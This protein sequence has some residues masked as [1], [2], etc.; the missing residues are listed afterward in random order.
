MKTRNLRNA[1]TLLLAGGLFAAH[2]PQA[3]AAAYA[4]GGSGQYRNEV[5]WLTWGGGVNGTAG[6]PLA[7][8]ATTSATI[9]VT[10]NQDLV[11]ECSLS[12]ISG[13]IESYRPGDWSGDA[14]DDMYNIGGTGAANQLITGIMGRTGTHGFTVECQ[15]TLGGLPYRIPGLVMADAESMNTTTEYL[16]GTAA[17]TWNVVEVYT[18]NGNRYD[19]RK[20][21]VGGGLQAIRFGN[22]GGEQNGTT[23]PAGVTFLTFDEAAYGPGESI[24]MAFEIL[25]GG[26]TAI[27]IGLLAPSADFGDAPGSYGDAAHLLRGLVAEPDGLAPGAGAIDINTPGFQLGQLAPP[28]SG[29]LGSIGPDGEPGT[30]A[31]VDADGDDSGGSAGSA[32]EDAWTSDTLAITGTAQPI[33]R[34]IACVGTGTV[35]GWIDFDHN[36]AFDPDERAQAACSGGAAALSWIVPA[37]V[38]PGSSYVRLRYATDAAEVQSPSGEAADGEAEDHAVELEL[39]VDVSLDKVVTPTNASVGQVVD[40]TVTVGNAGPFAADGAVVTD[41]PVDGLDCAPASV[42]ACSAS[43]GAQCPAAATVGDLQG[44]GLTIPALP[45]GGELVLEYQCTVAD[46]EP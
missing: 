46:P 11:L 32:E 37:D 40:Y 35:A 39:A 24:T 12:G 10:A 15:A 7:D 6:L 33:D 42:V 20:D 41:P 3:H 45:E 29:F 36:G 2:L 25:G 38:S 21:D 16:E 17:G 27:A 1:C 8:G 14:L 4:T 43:G 26:N 44:A 31:G 30:Q 18:G 9:P 34:S 22:P 28:D 23:S 5:L 19:A 13:T